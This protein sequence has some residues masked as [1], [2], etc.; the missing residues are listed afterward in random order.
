MTTAKKASIVDDEEAAVVVDKVAQ[1]SAPEEQV[2]GPN[3]TPSKGPDEEVGMTAV[4]DSTRAP[5]E[6]SATVHMVHADGH[7]S[8]VEVANVK[9]HERMGWKRQED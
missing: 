9:M 1:N 7:E 3:G 2:A 4:A 6:A 8:D 5:E